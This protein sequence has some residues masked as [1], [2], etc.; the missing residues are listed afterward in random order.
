MSPF[1]FLVVVL[2]SVLVAACSDGITREEVVGT[3]TILSLT[4]EGPTATVKWSVVPGADG[5]TVKLAADAES[6]RTREVAAGTT[7]TVFENLTPERPY[8][9]AVAARRN[10]RTGGWD[11]ERFTSPPG[12]PV[13]TARDSLIASITAQLRYT[14]HGNAGGMRYWYDSPTGFGAQ[15]GVPYSALTCGGCHAYNSALTGVP[16]DQPCLACHTEVAGKPGVPDYDS[17]DQA[18]CL[19]CHSRQAAEIAMGLPDAHRSAG[20][21]CADCHTAAEVHS[22]G[23]QTTMFVALTTQCE[24]CHVNGRNP[25]APKLPYDASHLTHSGRVGCQSCHMSGSVTCVNCHLDDDLTKQQRVAYKKF[26]DWIFLGNWR[27]QV[28]PLNVQ[29]VEYQG[30]TLAAWGPFNGHTIVP[31]GRVCTDCHGSANV[32][33]TSLDVVRWNDATKTLDHLTG[34]I[35]VPPDYA[36][37]LRFDFMVKNPDGSWSFL[38]SGAGRTQMLFATPLTQWQM[39]R[40]SKIR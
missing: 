29:T 27:G 20:M 40:L 21:T 17:V 4:T 34:V 14:I 5:Y 30:H 6:L 32:L 25:A 28:R 37:R 24:D 26:A 9:V 13:L 8:E 10:G 3:P 1:R 19:K 12:E 23:A 18:K 39:G 2:G 16:S 36:T 31:T 33:A 7:S 22:N 11:S 35:P 38:E 15:S